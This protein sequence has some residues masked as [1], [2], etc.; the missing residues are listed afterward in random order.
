MCQIVGYVL[1]N[2]QKIQVILFQF[3]HTQTRYLVSVALQHAAADAGHG[4]GHR[5]DRG[6]ADGRGHAQVRVQLHGL[7]P[8]R[9]CVTPLLQR[10]C[11]NVTEYLSEH[12]SK[13]GAGYYALILVCSVEELV[14]RQV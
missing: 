5:R 11:S 1:Q 14:R 10:P 12:L 13:Y 6:P 8:A 2:L 4:A 7:R 9:R 3:E